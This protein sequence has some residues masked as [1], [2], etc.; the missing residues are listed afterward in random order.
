MQAGNKANNR[1]N[2]CVSESVQTASLLCVMCTEQ[3]HPFAPTDAPSRKEGQVEIWLRASSHAAYHLRVGGTRSSAK[4]GAVCERKIITIK[5]A[6]EAVARPTR[7]FLTAR[8]ISSEHHFQ[9]YFPRLFL[10]VFA[11]GAWP[12]AKI[13]PPPNSPSRM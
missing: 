13:P 6:K 10:F 12:T 4:R 2:V 3:K 9:G 1:V 7:L 8:F 11:P 5:K